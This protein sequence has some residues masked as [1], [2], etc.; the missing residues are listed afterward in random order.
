M[1]T[2]RTPM[3][4]FP[5]CFSFEAGWQRFISVWSSSLSAAQAT[6]VS[7]L[8][9]TF[10]HPSTH[11][12]RLQPQIW[13]SPDEA[14]VPKPATNPKPAP[15]NDLRLVPIIFSQY[16]CQD[17]FC[18][19]AARSAEI[20]EAWSPYLP[21][22]LAK[23]LGMGFRE[24]PQEDSLTTRAGDHGC[25]SSGSLLPGRHAE[26]NRPQSAVGPARLTPVV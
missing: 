1:Q 8:Y 12:Q 16:W 23:G 2:G 4:P 21:K 9:W 14:L 18:L 7:I 20:L 19:F 26:R 25:R 22:G 6:L 3:L 15:C 17:R 24:Y 13:Q 11:R 10:P 5:S